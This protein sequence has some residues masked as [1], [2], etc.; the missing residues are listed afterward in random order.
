MQAKP[1][2]TV[3]RITFAPGGYRPAEDIAADLMA[4]RIKAVSDPRDV[5]IARLRA[6]LDEVA[7]LCPKP[8]GAGQVAR[9][10]LKV[11]T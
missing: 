7:R 5:E 2:T 8:G 9:D 3:G 4:G 10:A 1:E 11:G 6:A